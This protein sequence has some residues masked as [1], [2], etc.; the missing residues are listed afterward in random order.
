MRVL[1]TT[2]PEKTPFLTMAPL[3]WALVA[4]GHEVRF[5][6]QPRFAGV[7]T[8]AGLTA[9]PVGSDRDLFQ[10]LEADPESLEEGRSGVPEPYDAAVERAKATWDHLVNGYDVAVTWWHKLENLPMIA[11]LVAFARAWRPDLVI[12]EPTTYAGAI[13]AKA[14]G[15]VHARLLH[16]L[17]VFGV[18]RELFLRLKG[19][20]PEDPLADWLG[21]YAARYGADYTED[22]ATGHFT[23][24]QLPGSLA[25]RPGPSHLRMR[26]VPYGGPAVVPDWLTRPPDRPRVALTP[27]LVYHESDEEDERFDDYV[28]ELQGL[29]DT[30]SALDIEIVATL[31][32]K[33]RRKLAR[34]PPNL[35]IVPYVPLQPL[36]S[37]CVAA[38]HHAGPGTLATVSL[39]GVPQLALPWEV[40]E[41]ALAERLARHGAGLALDSGEATD[42]LV[43]D[44]LA[45]L[46]DEPSFRERAADLREEMLELPSPNQLVRRLEELVGEHRVR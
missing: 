43:R 6:C 13:A 29:L 36:L 15:A 31:A 1:F 21:S 26:Y 16:S 10:L 11:D 3:A 23:I 37:T 12:W 14:S 46:L 17:D 39:M 24:D 33:E 45:R 30:I 27:G 18:T 44:S 22:L 42:E 35:R 28:G 38:V 8:Q 41:P 4:G 9:V 5:A 7:I 2:R 40:D 25:L 32:D 34:V 20:R 19:D